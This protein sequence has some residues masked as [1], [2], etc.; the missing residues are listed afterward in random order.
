MRKQL[1]RRELCVKLA[2]RRRI[3]WR[4]SEFLT[5]PFGGPMFDAE[6]LVT[7]DEVFTRE[8]LFFADASFN[9]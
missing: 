7:V 3:I 2:R 8:Q 6:L 9:R 1:L 4:S 5:L